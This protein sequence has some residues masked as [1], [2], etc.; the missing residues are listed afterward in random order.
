[1]KNKR[2]ILLGIS[3]FM[4]CI[5]QAWTETRVLDSI[6]IIVN[7]EI[8][9]NNEV[10]EVIASRREQILQS[11]PEGEEREQQLARL[12]KTS[13]ESLVFELLILDR[14]KVLNIKVSDDEIEQQINRLSQENPQIINNYTPRILKELIAKEFLT[15]RVIMREVD[16]KIRVMD[17]EIEKLCQENVEE[18]KELVIAQILF[19]GRE[20]EARSK[21]AVV[22][23]AL[24]EG[25][26]FA[27][28]AKSYSDDPNARK[29]GGMIG[30]FQKG[31]LL[32]AIDKVAFSLKLQEI[33][34]L[35]KTEIGYHLLYLQD[36]QYNEEIDCSNLEETEKI[37]YNNQIFQKKL[38]KALPMYLQK[39]RET[40]Q[41]VIH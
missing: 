30:S 37:Q 23:K 28:L 35:V 27:D 18:S 6:K 9:T 36:V 20:E 7:N 19:R 5:S 2:T 21:E 34:E 32:P 15:Q 26:N 41:V 25:G 40:A 16:M 13:I 12:E 4:L 1:M 3:I 14:A 39:L 22:K 11:V 10:Q 31:E 24:S 8:L 33:S 38:Q 17:E 29:T